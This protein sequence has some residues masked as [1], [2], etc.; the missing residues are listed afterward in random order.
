MG[1]RFR[2][3]IRIFPSLRLNLS[4]SGLGISAGPRGLKVGACAA[5]AAASPAPGVV[6][7]RHVGSRGGVYHYSSSGRKVYERR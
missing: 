5:R 2:R 1:F 3:S 4:R 7:D 6:S